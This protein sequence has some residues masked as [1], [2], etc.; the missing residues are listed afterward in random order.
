LAAAPSTP[1]SP[2][3]DACHGAQGEGMA[4][5]H[6]PRLTGQ[7]AEY[8]Q[9]QLDDYASGARDNPIMSN[10]A[11]TLSEEQ[12]AQLAA[13]YA[14]MSA[15]Y[16]PEAGTIP[17]ASQLFRGH[18]LAHQGDAK[19]QVQA[20][21][22]CH[23]PDG[24]GVR[25][26]APYPAGQSAEY[27]A[28]ALKSFQTETRKND[29]GQLMRTVAKRLH[30]ADISALSAYFAQAVAAPLAPSPTLTKSP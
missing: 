28:T 10:F 6:V 26:A 22:S 3:C 2:P 24:S 27:I 18:Q 4:A 17:T 16:L 25:H 9:K 14:G 7:S 12:R 8:L 13:H 30:D 20:C 1:A 23:G 29:A 11:K 21:N 5:A 15:A 19:L